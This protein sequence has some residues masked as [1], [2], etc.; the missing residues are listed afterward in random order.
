MSTQIRIALVRFYL[1]ELDDAVSTSLCMTL[2]SA[3][4]DG[5][6]RAIV[7]KGSYHGYQD[8]VPKHTFN[9][10]RM[11]YNAAAANR[12]MSDIVAVLASTKKRSSNQ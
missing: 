12:T 1:A 11:G 7:F 4:T 5:T 8:K 9:G 3:T 6:V 10:W 2:A